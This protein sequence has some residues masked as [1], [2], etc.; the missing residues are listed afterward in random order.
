MNFIYSLNK[1][2]FSTIVYQALFYILYYNTVN[3]MYI[4]KP[5][6]QIDAS[7]IPG[8]NVVPMLFLHTY[9]PSLLHVVGSFL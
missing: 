3:F 6:N 2:L 8:Y 5:M 7:S 9:S 1:Y 4:C